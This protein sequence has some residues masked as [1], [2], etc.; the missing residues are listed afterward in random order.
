V[1]IKQK[2]LQIQ[3]KGKKETF[4]SLF[5]C[6]ENYQHHFRPKHHPGPQLTVGGE[7]PLPILLKGLSAHMAES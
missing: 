6:G 3:L 4:Q 7:L 2:E 1:Q 5:G